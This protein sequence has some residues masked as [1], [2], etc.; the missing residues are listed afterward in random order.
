MR[1]GLVQGNLEDADQH[2]M[3]ISPSYGKTWTAEEVIEAFQP[4]Q[5]TV[6]TVRNWLIQA[7]IDSKRIT[8]SDNKA[9]LA[10]DAT[11]V[12]AE[13]LLRTE[14]HE[15][16]DRVSGAKLPSCDVYHVPAHVKPHI[17]FIKP[18]VHLIAPVETHKQKKTRHAGVRNSL[19]KREQ[20][21]SV[22]N[23]DVLFRKMP[24]G[25]H[26][27][28]SSDLSTCDISI[29]PE[30]LAALYNISPASTNVS[31][32]NSL[33]IFESELQYY[34]QEDLDLFFT[35]LTHGR[36]PNGTH[37]IPAN[38]DGG[39]QVAPNLTSA[40]TE[41][42]LDLMLAYPIVYPQTITLYEV[43]DLL[44]QA[45][46]NDTYTYGFNTFLDALDGSYCTYSAYGE[47]GNDPYLDQV[48]PDP[49]PGGYKGPLEC[50]TYKPTN[51]ISL[52][53][54]GQEADVP[55]AYQKR[56][57]NEYLKLGLQGVSILFASGDS[58]VSNYPEPYGIDGPTGCLGPN[59]NIFNPTW[60]VNCPYVTAVGA[61][62]VYPGFTVFQNES[63]VYDPAGHP[64][65]VN[66]SSGGGFSNIYGVPSYQRKAVDTFFADHNPPYP[67]Y[68]GLSNATGDIHDITTKPDVAALAGNSSGIYN[69]IGR[70]IPDVAANGD[71]SA[72]YVGGAYVQS[73]GTSA[74]TPTFAAIINRINEAR[75][76]AGKSLLGFLN[77]AL[78]ANPAMLN[79]IV[80]G[81]NPGCGTRGFDAVDGWDPVTGLGT[82]NFGKMREYFLSLP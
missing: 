47:T 66:Y 20:R 43:D 6:A 26:P 32:N 10:F 36:I 3:D 58:G 13:N 28:N 1:I 17:D 49:R 67:Y 40:G 12:E 56:Q 15:Y 74:A 16:H 34:R 63:A 77:P 62:K 46:P 35:N 52:S 22:Q 19:T 48:Y 44:V 73:G 45:D 57:C 81:S 4:S 75:L 79:D 76:A 70:G 37:P 2:L 59:L 24:A 69:R 53:Y 33:G 7:G 61:T 60:P 54:G 9:W 42:E 71:N 50:G 65:H 51:V 11:A 18:G 68:S 41:V 27:T 82:P 25:A 39:I 23:H 78:Y 21:G 31:A 72:I 14:Y 30:C 80:N 8:H 38:I 29:T 55:V 5:D 64:Y